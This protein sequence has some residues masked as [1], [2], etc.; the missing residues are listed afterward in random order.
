M[1][2]D[3]IDQNKKYEVDVTS[4]DLF[5]LARHG[6]FLQL[7]ALLEEGVDPNSKD[8]FGNTIVIVGA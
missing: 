6:K 7:K 4:V 1:V 5:S 3:I 8:R 2:K